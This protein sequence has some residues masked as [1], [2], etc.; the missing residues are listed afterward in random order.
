MNKKLALISVLLFPIIISG[1]YTIYKLPYSSLCHSKETKQESVRSQ[2]VFSPDGKSIA[3][4]EY[5]ET[6]RD[7]VGICTFP[8][9]GTRLRISQELK[10]FKI[11]LSTNNIQQIS[12]F[13]SNSL[14]DSAYLYNA[15]SFGTFAWN[16]NYIYTFIAEGMKKI[17]NQ[18]TTPIM[19]LKT[20]TTTGKTSEIDSIAGKGIAEAEYTSEGY[21]DSI[22]PNSTDERLKFDFAENKIHLVSKDGQEIKVLAE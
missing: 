18:Y 4:T 1:V 16:D 15:G 12:S 8:H 21:K 11:D 13:R 22:S 14:T 3:F 5:N 20:D 2:A 10:L 6:Y 19:Y 17:D 9:G 7:P